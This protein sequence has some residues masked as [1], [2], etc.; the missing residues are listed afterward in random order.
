MTHL[1]SHACINY[2]QTGQTDTDIFLIMPFYIVEFVYR[3]VKLVFCNN[4]TTIYVAP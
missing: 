4:K 1:F 2:L 3:Y